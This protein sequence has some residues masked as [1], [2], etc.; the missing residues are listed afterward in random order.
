VCVG[1]LLEAVDEYLYLNILLT[2]IIYACAGER[3][4]GCVCVLLETVN[5]YLYL[6]AFRKTRMC[7]CVRERERVCI[8][9]FCL[10]R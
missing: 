9:V 2:K 7:V 4:S 10:R 6:Y 3:E 1:V 8:C 5:R